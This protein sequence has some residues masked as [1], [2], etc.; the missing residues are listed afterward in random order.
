MYW[1]RDGACFRCGSFSHWVANCHDQDYDYDS[2]G[3]IASASYF[4]EDEYAGYDNSSLSHYYE[5]DS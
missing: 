1:K 3:G 4:S 2:S 5:G